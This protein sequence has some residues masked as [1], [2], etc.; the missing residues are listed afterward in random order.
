MFALPRSG[1]AGHALLKS[2]CGTFTSVLSALGIS[3]RAVGFVLRRLWRKYFRH[4]LSH[5]GSRY[6]LQKPR[7]ALISWLLAELARWFVSLHQ[8]RGSV[9]ANIFGPLPDGQL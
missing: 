3:P 1:C 8:F 2:R 4:I 5:S 9:G 6:G 7:I